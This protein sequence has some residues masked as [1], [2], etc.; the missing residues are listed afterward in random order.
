MIHFLIRSVAGLLNMLP[1]KTIPGLS[2]GHI[3]ESMNMSDVQ[4][5][6]TSDTRVRS[7]SE[8][9]EDPLP[10]D[11]SKG[12]F[13][14][15]AFLF[16]VMWYIF[17]AFTLF[18]NKYI[19]TIVHGDATMLGTMQMILTMSCGFIQLYFPCGMYRPVTRTA[20][21]PPHFKRNMLLVGSLRFLTVFLGLVA[22]K[23]VAVSFTETV[24]SSAPIFTVGIAF[25]MT[26]ERTG[27]YTQLSLIP[28]MSGLALCSAY[29]LSFNVQGFMFALSTNLC[30]CLQNVYSKMLICGTNFKYTPAE[31]Q[32]YTS[33]AS[34]LVQIPT[35][36]LLM[37][38]PSVYAN[39]NSHLLFI[40]FINGV[41]FHYQT[42]AAYV[43]MG[44]ISPVTHSVANTVKRAFLIWFSVIL[45]GNPVTFLSGLGTAIVMVGVLSYNKARE[46]DERQRAL[47]ETFTNAQVSNI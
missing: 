35:C 21:F 15:R 4:L 10:A 44:Y 1:A 25:M 17:S 38:F 37:D 39:T 31:M 2:N 29:E 41:C 22:L 3:D 16:L 19:L 20:G 23:Y 13:S 30:E 32:F 42:I 14:A 27:M 45:F 8:C 28:I 18:L 46:I 5:V 6:P 43:L 24:K 9:N 34:I 7:K 40:Y 26:G 33:I 36:L 47:H 11:A 12:L